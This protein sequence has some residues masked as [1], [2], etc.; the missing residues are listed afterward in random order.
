MMAA[1]YPCSRQLEYSDTLVSCPIDA[2]PEELFIGWSY[3]ADL[4][5]MNSGGGQT[6]ELARWVPFGTPSGLD[7]GGVA[8]AINDYL[9]VY[10][11]VSELRLSLHA[12]T[13]RLR[14]HEL[15]EAVVAE[16][17]NIL[18]DRAAQLPGGVTVFDSK[19][20]R[21]TIPHKEQL[22]G[23]IR[24]AV[25][26]LERELEGRTVNFPFEWRVQEGAAVDIRFLEDAIVRVTFAPDDK[27]LAPSGILPSLP[28]NRSFVWEE[29]RSFETRSKTSPTVRSQSETTLGEYVESLQMLEGWSNRLPAVYS[30][31]PPG[32]SITESQVRWL[33]AGSEN[34][35]PR[36]LSR[37][38]ARLGGGDAQKVLW[39]W[40]PPYLPR[41][42]KES[43]AI[44]SS[45]NPYTVVA[46]L[47]KDF[48]ERVEA[49]LSLITGASETSAFAELFKEL[50]TRA[51]V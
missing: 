25:D 5:D 6:P 51:W 26:L 24:T 39:E 9:R 20:R 17:G 27:E 34:L 23:K 47:G 13:S 10:P 29:D 30:E 42:W 18:R 19:S 8:A 21:G 50:G 37:A 31:V 45:A 36:I 12:Q 3:L 16:L 38:L 22:L 43:N 11:Y 35:D 46:S 2:G 32:E 1:T 49:E 41:R 40:R 28:I 15:D 14:S 4:T 33:V 44:F 48:R 7:K